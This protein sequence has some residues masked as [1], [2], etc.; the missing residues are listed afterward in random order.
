MKERKEMRKDRRREMV[1]TDI[2]SLV[3]EKKSP[4]ADSIIIID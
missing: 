1:M 2:S 4:N 3:G